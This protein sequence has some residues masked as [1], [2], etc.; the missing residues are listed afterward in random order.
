MA[1]RLSQVAMAIWLGGTPRGSE[2]MRPKAAS[3]LYD[4]LFRQ[5]SDLSLSLLAR[6]LV[7]EVFG[8]MIDY[9]FNCGLALWWY[10]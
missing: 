9:Y 1:T 2:L 7:L 3:A 8:T 6:F 4:A 5:V 10:S